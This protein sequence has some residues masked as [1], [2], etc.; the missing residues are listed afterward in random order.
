MS[1]NQWVGICIHPVNFKLTIKEVNLQ[2]G[3]FYVMADKKRNFHFR[4]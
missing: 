4:H 1:F 2:Y 3:K